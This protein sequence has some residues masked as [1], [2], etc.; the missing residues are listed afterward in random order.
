MPK[1]VISYQKEL[2]EIPGR[3]PWEKPTSFLVKD[4]TAE[5]GWRVDE[6]GRRRSSLLLANKLREKVDA[7]READYPG[8]SDITR[9][10]FRYWFEED[11]E[12][13]GFPVSFRYHFC[14]REAIETLAYVVEI[15][16]NRDAKELIDAF[17]E[18][19]QKICIPN[20]PSFK[21]SPDG[22]RLF[23]MSRSLMPMV[24]R[25][26]LLRISVATP[27]GWLPAQARPGLS[28]WLWFGPTFTRR[29]CLIQIF[30]QTS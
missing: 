5:T 20:R 23:G 8:A 18:V 7:W 26:C 3:C 4:P 30:R 9:D 14:Q 24:S 25:I 10:L 27:S 12:I 6:S 11:H 29:G 17:A 19:F 21:P 1:S 15:I 16:S 13:A 2:P 22:G 28:Q